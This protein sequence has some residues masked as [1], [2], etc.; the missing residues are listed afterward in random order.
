MRLLSSRIFLSTNVNDSLQSKRSLIQTNFKNTDW[1]KERNL[2]TTSGRTVPWWATGSSMPSGKRARMKLHGKNSQGK[3]S[4][5]RKHIKSDF[6]ESFHNVCSQPFQFFC[7]W[8]IDHSQPVLE[9][10]SNPIQPNFL[11]SWPSKIIIKTKKYVFTS[12]TVLWSLLHS[13]FEH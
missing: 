11:K 12:L 7:F 8:Y 4:Q 3:T 6:A 10:L 13:V 1:E 2:R 9:N 5:G